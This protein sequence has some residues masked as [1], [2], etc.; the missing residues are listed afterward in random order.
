M[1][2]TAGVL[3]T[4]LVDA[5]A[6]YQYYLDG[7]G[8]PREFSDDRYVMND[9]CGRVTLRNAILEAQ[10]FAIELYKSHRR[11]QFNFTGPAI[12]CGSFSSQFAQLSMMYPYPATENWQKAIG[13][14]YIWLSAS[15][16]V[17]ID[18]R[19]SAAPEFSMDFVI[20]A[21]DQYNFNPGAKDIATGLPDDANGRFV[22]VG[23]AHGYRN[24]AT[25]KRSFNWKGYQLGVASMGIRIHMRTDK[26]EL[27]R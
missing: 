26:P 8:K 10:Y 11:T 4:D 24:N 21:E 1:A 14:H 15:V 18:P 2:D 16:R 27:N 5:V 23:L 12:P 17:A 19:T 3:R 20:H 9:N 7:Q 25:L 22:V 6:A 13:A